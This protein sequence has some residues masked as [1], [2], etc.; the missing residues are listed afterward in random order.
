M[1]P[2]FQIG[3]C[4]VVALPA[5]PEMV[6]V[7]VGEQDHVDLAQR[8]ELLERGRR[9]RIAGQPGVDDDDLAAGRGDARGG[10]AEP[11]HFGLASG[12]AAGGGRLRRRGGGV[13][14]T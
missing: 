12:M 4:C 7:G 3:T 2:P 11:E 8:G 1:P 14:N 10:L 5:H 9:L 13:R 6:A